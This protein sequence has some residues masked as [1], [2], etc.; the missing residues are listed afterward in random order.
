MIIISKK[1]IILHGRNEC[2]RIIDID[3]LP[4]GRLLGYIKYNINS[5][6]NVILYFYSMFSGNQKG[7]YRFFS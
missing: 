3:I 1:N 2:E 6:K 4:T 5:K 7:R